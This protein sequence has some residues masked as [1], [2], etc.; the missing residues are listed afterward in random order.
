M[1]QLIEFIYQLDVYLAVSKV[2]RERGFTYAR[3]LDRSSNTLSVIDLFHPSLHNAV[4]N[5]FALNG[6]MNALFL[7]GANMAGKSTLMKAFGIAVYLAH[8]GFPVAAS[9]MEFS[10]KDGLYTSIN[11]QDLSF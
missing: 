8:M 9:A 3:A 7:T 2:G 1:A 4:G 10:V 5:S 6:E 11:V